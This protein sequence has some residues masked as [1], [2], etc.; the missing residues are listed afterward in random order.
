MPNGFN[1]QIDNTFQKLIL[2]YILC[3]GFSED[4]GLCLNI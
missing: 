4:T 1:F 2:A 3:I